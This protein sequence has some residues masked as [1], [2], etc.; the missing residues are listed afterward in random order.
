MEKNLLGSEAA[1]KILTKDSM[2]PS[3]TVKQRIYGFIGCFAFGLLLSILSIG[4][5]FGAFMD[6][7]KFSLTYSLGNLCSLGSTFFLIGPERQL[8][9][10]FKQTRYIA[11]IIFLS[12]LIGTLVF[13]IWFFDKE[14][15]WHKLFLLLLIFLQF[16]SLFWYTLSYI[17]FGRKIFKKICCHVCCEEE[18]SGGK[19]S[20]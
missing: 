11:S 19:T 12:S 6:P 2:C 20:G 17:P 4:G 18:E 3:L 5:I 8:K 9:R 10:M 13:A 1:G 15:W 7:L 14:V 16:C